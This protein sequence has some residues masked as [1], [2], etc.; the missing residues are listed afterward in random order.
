MD[1]D[2]GVFSNGGTTPGVPLEFQGETGLPLICD[3]NVGIPLKMK[4]GNG[5]SSRDEEGKPG[6]FFSCGGKL[7]LPLEWRRGC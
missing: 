1:R 7:G 3:R 5:I 6:H 4:Q 2:I